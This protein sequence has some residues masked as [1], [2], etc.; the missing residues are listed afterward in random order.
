MIAIVGIRYRNYT[1]YIGVVFPFK[2]SL[3]FLF[4][5]DFEGNASISVAIEYGSTVSLYFIIYIYLPHP[6]ISRDI[7]YMWQLLHVQNMRKVSK[8]SVFITLNLPLSAYNPMTT[9]QQIRCRIHSARSLL[10]LPRIQVS[11]DWAAKD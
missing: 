9:S 10:Y 11:K 2:R 7:L 1:F 6:V 4:L 3:S 8:T 5:H